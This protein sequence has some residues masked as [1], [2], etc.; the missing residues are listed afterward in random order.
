MADPTDLGERAF[1]AAQNLLR[2]G[3]EVA[4]REGRVLRLQAQV[5]RLRSQRN[6]LLHEMGVKVFDLFQRDLVKN[7]ALRLACQQVKGIDAEIEVRL[8]EIQQVRRADQHS[9]G[10]I[11]G[12]P[13]TP[14]PEPAILDDGLEEDDEGEI[15][16]E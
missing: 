11:D 5:S 10:G 8:E 7:Q 6:R 3:Q 13:E 4:K 16:R 2:R 9:E 1:T 15:I 14:A 12:E